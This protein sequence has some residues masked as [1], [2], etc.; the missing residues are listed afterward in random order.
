MP[1]FA[2]SVFQ[3]ITIARLLLVAV[4]GAAAETHKRTISVDR[5]WRKW[6]ATRYFFFNYIPLEEQNHEDDHE[7]DDNHRAHDGTCQNAHLHVVLLANVR[8]KVDEQNKYPL[9]NF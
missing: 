8:W 3:G 6:T 4:V 9:M 2:V 1:T 5:M 7:H